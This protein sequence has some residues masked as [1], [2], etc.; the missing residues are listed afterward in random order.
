MAELESFANVFQFRSD[1]KGQ[2]RQTVFRNENPIT[3]E[4]GC[5]KGEYTLA[6]AQR[7]SDRNFIGVDI[8]GPRLWCGAK[9]ALE[10]SLPNVRFLRA[11]IDHLNDYF[12]AGEVAEIWIVFP[13]PYP[14]KPKEKKRLTAPRFLELYRKIVQPGGC[15]HLKTDDDDLFVYSQQTILSV[16][17]RI[18]DVVTDV[19]KESHDVSGLLHVSTHY[20]RLHLQAGRTI[21]YLRFTL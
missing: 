11:Y 15:L 9:I 10:L 16:G 12:A 19:Y 7:F 4:L 18:W 13:D 5:G 8:K 1:L 17:G 2:W 21:K 3:L 14:N 20:E 6:L